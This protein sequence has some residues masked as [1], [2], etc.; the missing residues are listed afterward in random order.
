MVEELFGALAVEAQSV[1]PPLRLWGRGS[2]AGF[3]SLAAQ[4]ATE[5]GSHIF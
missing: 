5:R 1:G 3:F 4:P 2:C